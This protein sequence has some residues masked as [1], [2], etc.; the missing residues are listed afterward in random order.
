MLTRII[1]LAA[2]ASTCA[3]K[4]DEN[5]PIIIGDVELQ[6]L[7]DE[8]EARLDSLIEPEYWVLSY[9]Q[10]G[11]AIEPIDQGDSLIFSGIAM[12]VT[13]CDGIGEKIETALLDAMPIGTLF[14]HPT[15]PDQIS[16][17]GAL[18]LLFGIAA[19]WKYCDG[20]DVINKWSEF[21]NAIDPDKLNPAADDTLPLE[22][23]Y[24]LDVLKWRMGLAQAPKVTRRAILETQVASWAH[25]VVET[26][27]AC[28]RIH[29]GWLAL[30][31]LQML[32]EAPSSI[33]K[34]SFCSAIDPGQIPLIRHWCG[35]N[36]LVEYAKTYQKNE[37]SYRH[38]R[39]GG[40]EKPDG[41]QASR[42][43]VDMLVALWELERGGQ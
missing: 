9:R 40:W 16:M 3:T 2:L 21:V 15:L 35:G 28:Y 29:L 8:Y 7:R 34:A 41:A 23:R 4:K 5:P 25:A 18:G 42:P 43:G 12:G 22:F 1:I 26:K 38:Q 31:T 10:D 32:G 6:S 17:D 37:W 11:D 24:V 33:G 14:R 13:S 36:L 30:R 27:A 20:Q 19:R 39:C